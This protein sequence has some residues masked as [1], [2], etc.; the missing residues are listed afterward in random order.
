MD[1]VMDYQRLI[2]LLIRLRGEPMA[3]KAAATL[4]LIVV[5]YGLWR[6]LVAAIGYLV[7]NPAPRQRYW[8]VTR[9]TLTA[10]GVALVAAVWVEELKTVSLVLAGVAAG[11]LIS[12]KEVFLGIGGRLS[13]MVAD[14]YDIGDRIRINGLCGDVINIGLLYTWLLEVDVHDGENQATGRVTLVPHLWL[15]QHAVINSTLGHEYLWDEIEFVF[16]LDVD[17][18]RVI[19]L[20][21]RTTGEALR[22]EIATAARVVPRL[23]QHFAAKS[24]PVTPVAYARLVTTP[25][26][27]NALAVRLRYTVRARQRRAT[28]SQITLRVLSALREAGLSP[29]G[30]PALPAP[31]EGTVP[32]PAVP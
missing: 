23:G 31:A 25:V 22:A 3:A 5:F 9:F 6:L 12:G 20:L 4:L 18:A 1:E 29:L 7:T 11:I 32:P 17:G 27:Q 10:V 30:D 2:E 24:P 19:D 14:H 28:N 15:T 21:Q 26:G 16:A 8:N 13:L